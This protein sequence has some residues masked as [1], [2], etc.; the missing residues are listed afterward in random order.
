MAEKW[1][2]RGWA[3]MVQERKKEID[4]ISVGPILMGL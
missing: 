4:I 2:G 1:R 3:E